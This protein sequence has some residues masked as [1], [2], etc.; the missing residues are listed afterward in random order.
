MLCV[1]LLVSVLARKT[2]VAVGASIFIWLVFA[3]V[4]DLGL[5]AGT[6]AMRL[7]IQELFALSLVNPLQ[8]FKMWSLHASDGSLDVLGPA[9]LYAT[10]EF[11]SSLHA[12]FAGSLLA[13]AVIPLGAAS[14]IFARRSPL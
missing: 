13:W 12:I 5:M 14:V 7:S 8:V 3:F 4:T 10:E 9:G 6:L 1:G 11:G 2:S